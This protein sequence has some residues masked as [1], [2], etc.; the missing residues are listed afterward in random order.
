MSNYSFHILYG[1][2]ERYVYMK[3]VI[4]ITGILLFFL[5]GGCSDNGT[6]SNTEET[7]EYTKLDEGYSAGVKVV[8][9]AEQ[10]PFVGYNKFYVALYDSVSNRQLTDFNVSFAP[11]MDMG[12]MVHACPYEDP[13]YNS[14]NKLY[15][16]ACTFIMAGMWTFNVQFDKSLESSAL[17]SYTFEF[18]VQAASMVKNIDAK[19][20]SKYFIT[21][22]QPEKWQVGMNDIE[23]CINTRQTMMNFPAVETLNIEMDPWM[24]M[25]GGTGHG[26]P[27]NEN[28]S[29]QQNGHYSGKIN[30]TMSG[31]WDIN[32]AVSNADSV[33]MET[34]FNVT[35]D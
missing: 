13:V 33:I 5:F 8:L 34:T 16:G 17:Y 31:G 10:E 23:F 20:G 11:L 4:I 19:D 26:S 22:M 30:F 6:D 25:G 27:N 24:D 32:L 21:L 15:A 18:N 1:I 7:I 2:Q 3:K 9:Y 14:Q 35:V 12:T 29:H 28:P